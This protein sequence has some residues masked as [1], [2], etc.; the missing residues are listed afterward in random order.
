M[1]TLVCGLGRC[2]MKMMMHMLRAGGARVVGAAP[3]FEVDEAATIPMDAMWLSSLGDGAVKVLDPHRSWRGQVPA[4]AIWMDR[5][6]TEQAKS[7]VK[8]LRLVGGVP[9]PTSAWKAMRSGLRSDREKCM[10]LLRPLERKVFSFEAVLASPASAAASLAEW[11]D[12]FDQS[13]AASVVRRRSPKCEPS[14]GVESNL[15]A[16]S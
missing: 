2:G 4:R 3:A 13:A 6:D 1:L 16:L 10:R 5:D 9:I 15:L 12:A 11:F 7:Q 14:M 8:F